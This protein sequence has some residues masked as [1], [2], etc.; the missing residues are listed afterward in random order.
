MKNLSLFLM[1]FLLTGAA[2]LPH[3]KIHHIQKS[4]YHH[5]QYWSDKYYDELK[6][7]TRI[8]KE[9]SETIKRLN[10]LIIEKTS[11]PKEASQR[12]RRRAYRRGIRILNGN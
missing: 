11:E 4:N 8:M 6:E 2:H 9:Q 3:S 5:R 12:E 10:S 7:Q 1:L